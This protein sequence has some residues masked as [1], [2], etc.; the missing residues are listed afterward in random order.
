MR[1]IAL[2][3]ET[4]GISLQEGHRIIE[5]ACIEMIDR[6]ITGRSFH[7]YFNPDRDVDA[8]AQEVHG[9]TSEFLT[10][11]PRF[12]EVIDNLIDFISG[13]DLIIHNMPFD[14]AF[15]EHEL[16][17]AKRPD[18]WLFCRKIFDTLPLARNMFPR[19][20]NSLSALCERYNIDASCYAEVSG[21]LLD[22]M[23]L[24]ELYLRMTADQ[25]RTILATAH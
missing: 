24:A 20:R 9:I 23:C 14:I 25:S 2:V 7:S 4:T 12:S 22:G 15:M 19:Q 16:A 11:K 18:L 5:M 21:A 10:D 17:L 3:I 1:Q 8:K 6:K 13:A